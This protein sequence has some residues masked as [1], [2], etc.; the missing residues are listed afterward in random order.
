MQFP[1]LSTLIFTPLIAGIVILCLPA[2][3]KNWIRGTAL[4]A[5][6]L[7][8]LLAGIVFASY[9]SGAGGYQFIE[10]YEWLPALGISFYAGVDGISLPLVLLSGMV[11][12][13]GVL[14]SWGIEDRPREFYAFLMFLGA[15]VIGVFCSLDLFMLFFFL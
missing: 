10:R 5:G 14:I 9:D 8:L 3:R 6:A 13:S 11:I 2:N 4:A 12:I 15:S 1:I 7:V